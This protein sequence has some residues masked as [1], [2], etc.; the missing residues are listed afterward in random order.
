MKPAEA[1]RSAEAMKAAKEKKPA[2]EKVIAP[3]EDPPDAKYTITG[4][5]VY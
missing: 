1:K 5:R 4:K 2:G 3:E